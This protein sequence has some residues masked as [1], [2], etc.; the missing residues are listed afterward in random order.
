MFVRQLGVTLCFSMKKCFQNIS[1]VHIR[2]RIFLTSPPPF[3]LNGRSLKVIIFVTS[4][5]CSIFHQTTKNS[6][7]LYQMYTLYAFVRYSLLQGKTAVFHSKVI[8]LVHS[9]HDLFSYRSI[10]LIFRK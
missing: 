7:H 6:R 1:S 5:L 8:I 4:A 2:D 3:K 9:Q 10:P